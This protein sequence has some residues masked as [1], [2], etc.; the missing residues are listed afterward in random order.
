MK[1]LIILLLLLF[2]VGCGMTPGQKNAV[3]ELD[4][5]ADF[6]IE[7]V[8]PTAKQPIKDVIDVNKAMTKALLESEGK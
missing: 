8:K 3:N 1:K 7:H 6:F 4:K 2:C 5:N